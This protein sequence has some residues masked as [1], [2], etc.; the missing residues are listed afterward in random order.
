MS[1]TVAPIASRTAAVHPASPQ[2]QV[3]RVVPIVGPSHDRPP[4]RTFDAEA[5]AFVKVAEVSQSGSVPDLAVE[6]GLDV[7][8]YLMD[9]QQLV[10]AKQNRILNTDVMVPARSTVNIPVS[11]VEAGRWSYKSATFAAGGSGSHR[12]RSGKSERVHANLKSTGRHDAEQG[13]VWAEVAASLDAC[14]CSSPTSSLHDGYESKR[15]ELDDFRKELKLPPETVGLAAFH[16]P[17]LR[18]LDVFDR[19]ATLAYFFDS[20]VDS[21]ALDWLGA[22]PE[23]GKEP[24]PEEA[25]VIEDALR[26]ASAAQ[27][28]AF[29]APGEGQDYRI[30]DDRLSGSALVWNDLVVHLQLFPKAGTAGGPEGAR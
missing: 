11:C 4:Y 12:V 17:H 26:R 8:L 1:A 3:L 30:E 25:A 5:K 24:A 21:Y 15:K 27:W 2:G 7:S 29:N 18:G 23:V 14:K 13:K 22:A 6:N 20:L 9:G 10:G 16:G 19:H 28:N